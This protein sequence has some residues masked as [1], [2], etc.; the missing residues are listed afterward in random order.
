MPVISS[1]III[2][3]M[4]YFVLVRRQIS[5]EYAYY[6]L[7][8]ACLAYFLFGRSLQHFSAPEVS[9]WLLYS[10]VFLLF[11]LGMPALIIGASLQVGLKRSAYL[12]YLP[13]LIG[14]LFGVC[15]VYFMG[16]FQGVFEPFLLTAQI[17]LKAHQ[18]YAHL[19]QIWAGF[20]L[21]LL[22]CVLLIIKAQYHQMQ[23]NLNPFLMGALSFALLFFLGS[24][25]YIEYWF[26]YTGSVICALCWAYAVF[27]NIRN[28]KGKAALLKD[29]LLFQIKSSRAEKSE[30]ISDLLGRL[31]KTSEGDLELYKIRVRD[32]LNRL[33]DSSIEAGGDSSSLILRHQ[34]K[35]QA[36]DSSQ[37]M[38]EL[39]RLVA[40]EA[41][42]YSDLLAQ[43]ADLRI[44]KQVDAAKT[45]LFKEAHNT[46]DFDELANHIGISKGH[47][48]RV[49]K[50]HMGVTLNQYLAQIR[51]EKA[52]VFLK[53]HSVTDTAIAVGFNNSNYFSTVFK[54]Q[55]GCTP[56]QF[57]IKITSNTMN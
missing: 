11:S 13:W 42:E 22:P 34:V 4:I 5:R 16:V 55:V 25:G 27:Q 24:S 43:S 33:T 40:E 44:K 48:M 15:Y 26:Y 52:K 53:T 30:E 46:I 49:F 56:G 32:I 12:M 54:K 20:S 29:E 39:S 2:S 10:R 45:Y 8:L 51:I 57:K 38:A 18:Q 41:A 3:V 36:I 28:I 47:L 1:Q 9:V 17:P 14:S 31:E 19:A 37:N 23:L 35:N 50:S 7:F 21:L 6:L